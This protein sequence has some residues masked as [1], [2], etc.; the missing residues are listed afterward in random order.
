MLD[1]NLRCRLNSQIFEQL[2]WSLER[3]VRPLNAIWLKEE[4]VSSEAI[5]FKTEGWEKFS[6]LLSKEFNVLVL[7]GEKLSAQTPEGEEIDVGLTFE[8]EALSNFCEQLSSISNLSG[9]RLTQ[10]E[11]ASRNLQPN[12]AKI[13]SQ[14]TLSLLEFFSA[15]SVSDREISPITSQAEYPAVSICQPIENAL[16]Q[17]IKQEQLLYRVTSQIRKTLELPAIL[18]TAVEEVR[19]CLEVDRLLIYEFN[20]DPSLNNNR[21]VFQPPAIDSESLRGCMTYE[22]L[23]SPDISSVLGLEIQNEFVEHLNLKDTDINQFSLATDDIEIAYKDRVSLLKSRQ[24]ARVRSELVSSIIVEE[25]L[26]GL[27]IAHQCS[28]LRQWQENDERFLRD[29]AEHLAVAIRQ[30]LLYHQL[31]KQKQTLEVQVKNQIQDLRDA[32]IAA[33]AASRSKSEFLAAMSHELRTPLTCVIGMSSTLLHWS[34]GQ[35]SDKQRSYLKK[36]YNSGEHLLEMINDLLE[37]SQLEA[38]NAVLNLQEISAI[39]LVEQMLTRMATKARDA[40]ISLTRDF[41]LNPEGDLLM[42]DLRRMQQV[43]HN[44]LSNAIKF[45]PA[46]GQVTVRLWREDKMLVLQVQDTG[47]GISEE[48]QTMI[49]NKFQQ[50]DSSY[51]RKYEGTGLGLALTK[52]LVELHGGWINVSSEEGVG[53]IFTVDLPFKK[54]NPSESSQG[55]EPE[56]NRRTLGRIVLIEEDDEIATNF[57]NLLT[58]DGYQVVCMVDGS[59]AV[60]NI[61]VLQ[62][63]LV[64]I[65]TPLSDINDLEVIEELRVKFT[66]DSLKILVL[67][68]NMIPEDVRSFW[69]AGADDYLIKPLDSQSFLMKIQDLLEN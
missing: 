7:T 16:D 47:V 57:C 41:Q 26:W 51:H 11:L 4:M 19:R 28:E 53:S 59:N 23:S 69:E 17:Q 58:E 64:I 6:L 67:I 61:E 14:F 65:D 45:T 10:I 46:G 50:L 24:K 27:L 35:F 31:Q 20:S 40:Q 1:V 52:Q 66:N 13:Q 63:N 56:M 43:L 44:L 62:P 68:S 48:H 5:A 22:S 49:F 2:L 42:A 21:E 3:L 34:F 12:N 9:D 18:S 8:T 55:N 32:L 25:K 36:I 54:I 29:I 15:S 38:G 39:E 30:S 33:E 60:M 37:L